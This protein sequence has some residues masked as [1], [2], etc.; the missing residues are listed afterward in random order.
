M[1]QH[2]YSN[3]TC[4]HCG[5]F[6]TIKFGFVRV[7]RKRKQKYHCNHCGKTFV[8]EFEEEY[9]RREKIESKV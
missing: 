3:P 5:M 1:T 9:Y 4:P 7:L 6:P 2:N 8:T